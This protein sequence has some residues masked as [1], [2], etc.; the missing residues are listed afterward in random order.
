MDDQDEFRKDDSQAI[1]Q[2]LLKSYGL[3]R[4]GSRRESAE[5]EI[6]CRLEISEHWTEDNRRLSRLSRHF[7]RDGNFD[8]TSSDAGAFLNIKAANFR[9]F[10][11][12]HGK[13][14][15]QASYGS[16][17][18]RHNDVRQAIDALCGDLQYLEPEIYDAGRLLL[19]VDYML[20]HVM[21]VE[22]YHPFCL[23]QAACIWFCM[24]SREWKLA[25]LNDSRLRVQRES[26]MIINTICSLPEMDTRLIPP[27]AAALEAVYVDWLQAT[28]LWKTF[29][30]SLRGISHESD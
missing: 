14:R 9:A 3:D 10:K 28:R 29:R 26:E 12:R 1:G 19:A 13:R 22:P 5:K 24:K 20:T 7:R 25:I 27:N 18:P 8:Y 16:A 15:S 21:N 11:S 17:E 23:E 2:S 4:H 6:R 30:Q